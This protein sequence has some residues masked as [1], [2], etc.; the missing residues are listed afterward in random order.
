M[1]HPS[2]FLTRLITHVC[3]PTFMLLAGVSIHL[4]IFRR[5]GDVQGLSRFLVTRGIWLIVLECTV[6]G[7]AFFF[8]DVVIVLQVIWAIGA[9]FVAMAVLVRLPRP[10]VGVLAI[11]LMIILGGGMLDSLRP[12]AT[13][14]WA[15]PWALLV[16]GGVLGS[17][18]VVV[19]YPVLP[20]LAIMAL[21]YTAGPIADLEP[22]HRNRWIVSIGLAMV[23]IFAT[24]RI[25]D[26]FGDP[27]HWTTAPTVIPRGYVF[28]D[29][30]KYPPSID[31]DLLM[32]GVALLCAPLLDR[33]RGQPERVLLT[34]GRVP[35][36]VYIVHLYL[37]HGLALL[38][39]LML[40]IPASAFAVTGLRMPNLGPY[41]WGF[42]LG[43]VFLA[44]IVVLMS[45][46]PMARRF[47]AYKARNRHW[48]LSYL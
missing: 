41:N 6:V 40:G 34:F 8:N 33:V 43:G 21:G 25:I 14:L 19:S 30:S 39:G 9:S 46:W 47:A 44:W 27:L 26:G 20:W 29:V 35:L 16:Q 18:P 15:A 12:Q 4:S 36:F 17:W 10:F 38:V 37:M 5:A 31:Y 13:D 45:V 3:A 24:L 32:I 22:P 48:W 1:T 42:G 28:F 23:A 7:F 11:S 2:V